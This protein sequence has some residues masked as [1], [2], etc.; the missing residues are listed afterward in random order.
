[1]DDKKGADITILD[2]SKLLQI[3]DV[4]VIATGAN[5]RQVQTLAES[6]DERLREFGRRPIRQE[7]QTEGEWLLLDYGDIVVHVFQPES[8]DYYSLDR[9][10]GDAPK[11]AWETVA[12]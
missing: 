1:M 12:S 7:G 10:W 5:R 4:F 3:V 8:R 9:L 6:V 2:V 11:L